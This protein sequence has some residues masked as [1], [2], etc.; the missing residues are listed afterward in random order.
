MNLPATLTSVEMIL[1]NILYLSYLLPAARVRP[2]VPDVL[3]L[4]TVDGDN[5]MLSVV[6]FRN[7][8]VK[9]AR[10]PSPR[11]AYDQVDV[12]TYVVD[13]ESGDHAVYFLR[14]GLSSAPAVRLFRLAGMPAEHIRFAVQ[15]QRDRRLRY[16]HYTAT[17]HWQGEVHV[18]ADET[19]PKVD[20]LPPFTT[21][22][23]AVLYL[24]D[25]LV[26]FY[27]PPG[28]VRRVNIWHPRFQPRVARVSQVRFPF[29]TAMQ[30]LDAGEIGQ[31]HSVLLVPRGHFLTHLPPK[32]LGTSATQHHVP[33]R[34][35][36]S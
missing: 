28:R 31:P 12:R 14:C 9:A 23:E 1:H 16:A 18:E 34:N 36:T 5:V 2:H 7:A 33:A 6:L 8:D 15:A 29:L 20:I 13:P 25:P 17:G 19:A 26:G 11:L 32:R 22:Q 4:A 27:G 21:A 24:T 10:L 35:Y 30:L 3:P